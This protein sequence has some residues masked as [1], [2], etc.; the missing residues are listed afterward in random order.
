MKLQAIVSRVLTAGVLTGVLAGPQQFCSAE[1]AQTTETIT[2]SG[3]VLDTSGDPVAEIPVEARYLGGPA[4]AVTGVDG[5][6][7]VDVPEDKWR[8]ANYVA[9]SVDEGLI[10]H[11]HFPGGR[12]ALSPGPIEITLEPVRHVMIH[13]SDQ[14]GRPISGATTGV[15]A[16]WMRWDFV[17]TDDDGQAV[18]SVPPDVTLTTVYAWKAGCGLDYQSQYDPEKSR[19]GRPQEEVDLSKPFRFTLSD[20]VTMDFKLVDSETEAPIADA[21]VFPTLLKKRGEPY[22]RVVSFSGAFDAWR[23]NDEGIIRMDWLPSWNDY[24]STTFDSYKPGYDSNQWR[25]DREQDGLEQTVK[26]RKT[27]PRDR[28][29]ELQTLQER[30][31][32]AFLGSDQSPKERYD[33]V[34]LDADLGMLRVLMILGDPDARETEPLFKA[35]YFDFAG[36]LDLRTILKQYRLLALP[37]TGDQATDVGDLTGELGITIDRD[38][39]SPRLLVLDTHDGLVADVPATGF[40]SE[41]IVDGQKLLDFLKRHRLPPRDARQLLDDALARAKAENKRV[42]VQ[43]T[44]YWCTPCWALSRFFHEHRQTLGTDY[45]H[46]KIDN[47]WRNAREV[48]DEI[49]PDDRGGL[50]WSAILDADGT[51]LANSNGPDGN[52][53]YPAAAKPAAIAYFL[54]MLRETRIRLTDDELAALEEDLKSR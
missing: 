38:Q 35:L 21:M 9:R 25:Y 47:R 13:V 1:V 7:S 49:E 39:S 3:R 41:G 46:V 32:G 54:S 19:A 30:I 42:F 16:D 18:H 22:F 45:I 5:R 23:T 15:V 4:K 12:S 14:E 8:W 36:N 33:V 37:T 40:E 10:G 28:P 6:F 27:V 50:P 52:I 48:M 51:V 17:P 29:V 31:A 2:I 53:A 11:A 20:P 44:A 26:R 43:Q 24:K 34:R